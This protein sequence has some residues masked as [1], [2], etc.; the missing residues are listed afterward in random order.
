MCAD[1]PL[2]CA[3]PAVTCPT[4]PE[5]P[6]SDPLSTRE[7]CKLSA[8]ALWISDVRQYSVLTAT[9]LGHQMRK[10]H[11]LP[12]RRP[13]QQQTQRG[14]EKNTL[15][16][17]GWGPSAQSLGEGQRFPPGYQLPKELQ[18]WGSSSTITIHGKKK[19]RGSQII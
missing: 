8:H 5:A 9:P 14:C 4:T 17:W 11:V 16:G 18:Q 12:W 13:S 6:G 15:A 3:G 19:K 1:F 7:P 10:H 2:S